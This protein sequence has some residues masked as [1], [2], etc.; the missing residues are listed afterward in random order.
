[1]RRI[2][3]NVKTFSLFRTDAL[4]VLVCLFPFLYACESLGLGKEED[5]ASGQLRIAFASDVDN[6]VR[7]AFNLPDTSDFILT[8]TSSDGSIIYN[9]SYEDSPEAMNVA[10]GG[11]LVKAVSCVFEKPAFDRPQFGDQQYVEVPDGG[12]IDVKLVCSQ[13]NSG[14]RL[15]IDPDF[16][17]VYP[18]GILFLR[19]SKGKLMYAY[20]EK[21]IAYFLPGTVSLIFSDSGTDEV[22]LSKNLAPQQ[23]L[24]VNVDVNAAGSGSAGQAD[25]HG[26]VSVAVDTTREWIDETLVIGDIQKG[27]DHEDALTVVQASGAVGQKDVWVSGYVVGGDLTPSSASYAIPFTSRT[28][29]LLGSRSTTSDRESCLAVQLPA[30]QVRDNL[31]LVD[32]SWLMGRRICLKGDIVEAYYGITGLKEVSDF[33]ID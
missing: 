12:V 1:M 14:V 31:N 30:G 33:V 20:S 13:M 3:M 32:N 16:L 26:R 21:R 7:S 6:D 18:D 23:I 28:N 4:C 19:S 5:A 2:N 24:T 22:L 25:D 17:E 29:I 11:Y 8:V 10:P 27:N 9:G 15:K